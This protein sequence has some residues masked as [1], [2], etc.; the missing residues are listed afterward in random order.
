MI[1]RV[2]RRAGGRS[3][4]GRLL[5]ALVVAIFAIASYYFGTTKGKTRL[6]VR[7]NGLT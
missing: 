7:C 3:G 5:I 4:G 6:P 2:G 1:G